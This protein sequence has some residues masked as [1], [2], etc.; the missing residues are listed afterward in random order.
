M[1]NQVGVLKL[2]IKQSFR[3]FPEKADIQTLLEYLVEA[4]RKGHNIQF[5]KV[6]TSK[7]FNNQVFNAKFKLNWFNHITVQIELLQHLKVEAIN[8]QDFPLASDLRILEK[9]LQ[10]PLFI[11]LN[12][13][14]RRPNLRFSIIEQPTMIC[15]YYFTNYSLFDVFLAKELKSIS[16][17]E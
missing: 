5:K 6:E 17:L 4:K 10:R 12:Q 14:C 8:R 1:K 16:I 9:K 2:V 7:Q 11:R 3:E 13:F 15:I